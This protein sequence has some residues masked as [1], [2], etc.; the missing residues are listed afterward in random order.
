VYK[1]DLVLA[2]GKRLKRLKQK[3][4]HKI[5]YHALSV[6]FCGERPRSRRYGRTTT[7]RPLAQ[8]ND[9]DDYYYYYY[10]YI[11]PFPSNGAPFE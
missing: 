9:E 2:E 3:P 10:Y 1:T 11:Y 6:S 5:P 4:H 7:S 8:L